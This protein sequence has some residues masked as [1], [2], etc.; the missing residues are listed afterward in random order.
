MNYEAW[1]ITFQSSE[2]AARA[3]F[4]EWQK[5]PAECEPVAIVGELYSQ[6]RDEVIAKGIAIGAYLYTVPQPCPDCL[7]WATDMSQVTKTLRYL[8]GI[9]ERGTAT[10]LP[11]GVTVESFVLDYVKG[12][13]AK[14]AELTQDLQTTSDALGH[15]ESNDRE[16]IE[17]QQGTIKALNIALGGEEST[18]TENL[19]DAHEVDY[20]EEG[21]ISLCRNLIAENVR[22]G[23]TIEFQK[24]GWSD[25][26]GTLTRAEAVIGKAAVTLHNLNIQGGLGY[27]NHR[28]IEEALTV[29]NEYR[30][31]K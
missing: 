9:A 18:S 10:T 24:A 12:L 30:E 1:R 11:D 4:A 14:V 23:D 26:Y 22:M 5:R 6:T 3:A 2:Q 8:I 25:D 19:I 28:L 15:A 27:T 31:W 21:L 29:V 7:K 17:E 20:N 13:E 16:L